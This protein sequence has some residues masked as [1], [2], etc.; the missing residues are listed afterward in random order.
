LWSNHSSFTA[1]P[2]LGV[3]ST[4]EGFWPEST[5]ALLN[6]PQML[7][8]DL[9]LAGKGVVAWFV[10]PQSSDMLAHSGRVEEPAF[11]PR[12]EQALSLGLVRPDAH[13]Q[14]GAILTFVEGK[15]A[16]A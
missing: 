16:I 2:E 11:L 5:A 9:C 6:A 1:T 13:P 14:R 7:L 4:H 15:G 10:V 8:P 3:D 12:R